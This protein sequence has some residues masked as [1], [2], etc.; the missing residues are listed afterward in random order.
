MSTFAQTIF[1]AVQ[2]YAK[3]DYKDRCVDPDGRKAF[4]THISCS[5]DPA[6]HD[7][8]YANVHGYI[9]QLNYLINLHSSMSK[10]DRIQ[11]SCCSISQLHEGAI[12]KAQ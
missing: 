6:A 7:K 8:I 9:G 3:K 2:T 10:E 4:L 1:G 5:T 11:T 12:R